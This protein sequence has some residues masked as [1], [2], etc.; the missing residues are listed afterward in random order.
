MKNG[1]LSTLIQNFIGDHFGYVADRTEYIS[2]ASSIRTPSAARLI[3]HYL[4]QYYPIP[5][6][7]EWW[8]KGFTEWTNVTRAVPQFVG[9][10]QP[11]LPADLGFYD[12]RLPEVQ[13]QQVALAKNAGLSAFSFY[14]YWFSGRT[15][16]EAP[17]KRFV[18]NEN[19]DFQFC[20]CWANEDWSRTWSG[21]ADEILISQ[22][23]S[24]EDDIAFIAH[25]ARYLRSEKYFRVDGKPLINVWRSTMLP[26]PAATVGRWRDWCRQNGIGEIH[27]SRCESYERLDPAD[28]GLDSAFQ[29]APSDSRWLEQN[30]AR[31]P[32]APPLL[33]PNFDGQVF[34]YHDLVRRSR[35]FVEPNYLLFRS[36]CPSWDNQARRPGAGRTLIGADPDSYRDFLETVIDQ[37]ARRQPDPDKRIVFINAWNEWGEGA[38]LEPDRRFGFGNLE[39]TK[40]ADLRVALRHGRIAEP[41]RIAVVVH[42]YYTELL[43]ECLGWIESLELPHDL[44]IT[45]A[46]EKR[47]TVEAFVAERGLAAT[48]VAVDNRGRD[49]APFLQVLQSLDYERYGKVL[50][51]HG[52]ATQ[53][54]PH[55]ASWR[56]GLFRTLADPEKLQRALALFDA[57]PDIGV[58]G[59]SEF[60]LAMQPYLG[61]NE[62]AVRRLAQRMGAEFEPEADTFFAGTMFIARTRA[63]L[64]LGALGFATA[65]FEPEQGQGNGTLAH[66]IERSVIYSA[67]AAGLTL[68]A[69]DDNADAGTGLVS[70]GRS[71]FPY[72]IK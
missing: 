15:L 2:A 59:P 42:V 49:V 29:H 19:I 25:I 14:F 60:L 40:M 4:P 30:L 31:Y 5:E 3:A 62:A 28:Q 11:H 24:P 9:H 45:T 33:N 36:V 57:N 39:A 44:F 32:G 7:D 48:V 70:K 35:E 16:L 17:L 65:D 50:K 66:A 34:D 10:Y 56:Q 18:E 47:A 23:Y 52:K 41:N 71:T 46:T 37:T 38:H 54:D 68:A 1:D 12:L 63:L 13:E 43:S 72:V 26:D 22:E 58:L 55:G 69:I 21:N 67:K 53:S 64:P 8:G 61:R 51:L 27:V 6:N 20:L